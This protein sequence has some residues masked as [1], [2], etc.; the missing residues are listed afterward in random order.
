MQTDS[1]VI[2]SII[3]AKSKTPNVSGSNTDAAVQRNLSCF[4]SKAEQRHG[5]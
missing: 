2:L 5:F 1:T 4:L 3:I